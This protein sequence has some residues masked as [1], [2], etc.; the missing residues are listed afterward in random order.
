MDR[1]AVLFGRH[2]FLLACC[3]LA[4]TAISLFGISR[5]T[6]DNDPLNLFSSDKFEFKW[7]QREF[8]HLEQTTLIVVQR[9]DLLTPEG[10]AAI[11]KITEAAAGVDGVEAVHSMLDVRGGRRVGRYLLP[12]FPS[13]GD[14]PWRFEQARRR[15]ESHPLLVGHFLSKDLKTSLVVVQLEGSVPPAA[16]D[17]PPAAGDAVQ[18]FSE[19]KVVLDRLRTALAECT[20]GS[21]M[22]VR[23]TGTPA[24]H[25]ELVE[26]MRS[27]IFMFSSL[28]ATLTVVIAIVLFRRIAAALLVGIGPLVGTIWAVGT[29]GLIGEPINMLT[30]VVPVLVLVIGFTDSMHLVLH[31]R[32]AVAGG[33][34]GLEA[35]RSSIRHLGLACALTSL[36]TAV[37]F[38]S[39]TLAS[40]QGIRTFGWCCALGSVLSFFAVITVVPLLSS[41]WLSRYVVVGEKRPTHWGLGRFPDRVLSGLIEHPRVVLACAA[42]LTVSLALLATKLEPDHRIASEIPHSSE[43]YRA[44]EH[45]DEKFGGILFAYA[46]V[47]WPEE[48]GLGSQELFDV[49]EEV[50]QVFDANQLLSNPLSILNLVKSLPG[51]QQES[52]PRRARQLRYVPEEVLRHLVYPPTHRWDT[53]LPHRMG[54]RAVVSAR[55][56]DVGARLLMPAFADAGRQFEQIAQRHPGF[57]IELVG[58]SVTAFSSVH[59]M[60]EDLWKSLLT[61]AGVMFLM[62]WV[63]LRSLRYAL[64]SLVPN[65]FPLLCTGAF[66]VLCGR[67]LE[68]SSVIVF[69]ISLGIAVD[70]TIHFLVRFKREMGSGG[71]PRSAV[72]RTFKVVGTALVMTTVAL[73]SGHLIVMMS[74]FPAVRVFGMLAAVTIASA[75]VGDLLILPAILVCIR[76]PRPRG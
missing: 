30:N 57:R 43:A 9:D 55:M 45:V 25:V 72:R 4:Y 44:L 50:H 14:P 42:V 3:V 41:T 58:D 51:E 7:L 31:V 66:I 68:M 23:I 49:L 6:F 76:W 65:V 29:L 39:L 27:D 12:F 37:G 34:S 70:D 35:A 74:A 36:S 26:N 53:K 69:S 61:A 24:L 46:I 18:S 52:L 10:L 21:R 64:A 1:L 19:F 75:L 54:G 73:V 48:R 60:I 33:S 62:I 59:L 38:G 32:R 40:L 20:E 28:G 16:G 11:R 67:Y 63:G 5:V 47:E 13:S 56:P 15:V 22:R 17:V 8:A 2:R 71:D